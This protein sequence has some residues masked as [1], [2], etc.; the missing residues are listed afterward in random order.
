MVHWTFPIALNAISALIFLCAFAAR[1]YLV[2]RMIEHRRAA[3]VIAARKGSPIARLDEMHGSGRIYL[4]QMGRH[5]A[6][7]SLNEFADWLRAK[8]ALDVQILPPVALDRSAWDASRGQYVGELLAE[9]LKSAYRELAADPQAYLIGFTDADMYLVNQRWN[10]AFT[11][12][13]GPRTAIISSDGMQDPLWQRMSGAPAANQKFQARLRRILL[14]DVA[15]LYWRLPLN[16][17]PASLLQEPLDT[18]LPLEDIYESDLH[19]ERTRWGRLEDEPCIF[20]V[21]TAKNGIQPLAGR[22]IRS[23]QDLA[24]LSPDESAELFEVDLRLGLLIDRHTDFFLPDTVPIQFE[25]A[26]RDGWRGSM[27]F[28]ISGTDNYDDYLSSHDGMHTINIVQSNGGRY[29]LKRVPAWL[30]VLSFV[31]YVDAD[32]SGRMVEM[33]WRTAGFQRFELKRYNGDVETYLP[34]SANTPPCFQIGYRNGRGEAL[35]FQRDEHRRLIWLQSPHNRWLS[36]RYGAGGRIAEITDSR[37]RTVDYG[38]DAGGRLVRVSYPSGEVFYYEY[39]GKQHLLS[40]SAAPDSESAPVVLLRNAYEHGRIV[41]QTL[42]GGKTYTYGY[43]PVEGDQ[44]Q[45]ARVR[46]PEDTVFDLYIGQVYSAIREHG[47]P[48]NR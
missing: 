48:P 36:L 11:F 14:K 21:Y 30:P 40:F 16:F 15:V 41:R 13:D 42:A 18:D 47:A 20:F 22:L 35:I 45:M 1:Y 29:N 23:C 43:K 7:Y 27:G 33:R 28:G 8:Y 4:V 32:Y 44:I 2:P 26:T 5:E 9:Q 46:T 34:C 25:R 3:E 12:R 39:D 31:K 38:Y 24:D 6:P 19:P 37:G 10:S 17:D